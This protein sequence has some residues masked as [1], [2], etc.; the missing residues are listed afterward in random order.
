VYQLLTRG[1]GSIF[2]AAHCLTD[3]SAD[4]LPV[5]SPQLDI[6]D[7]MRHLDRSHFVFSR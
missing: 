5:L 3:E 2:V 6:V 7:A 1:A 4:P